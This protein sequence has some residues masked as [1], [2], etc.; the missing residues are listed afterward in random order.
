[1]LACSKITLVILISHIGFVHFKTFGRQERQRHHNI[2]MFVACPS[3]SF[4]L[5]P[6]CNAGISFL[7]LKPLS[8]RAPKGCWFDQGLCSKIVAF[9]V[10]VVPRN[11]G[12]YYLYSIYK[13]V[14]FKLSSRGFRGSR[15][16]QCESEQNPSPNNPLPALRFSRSLKVSEKSPRP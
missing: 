4:S 2:A 13:E 7:P 14:V 5:F 12:F 11:T 10:S 9:M 15:G 16:P 3:A 1:M 6:L 8:L